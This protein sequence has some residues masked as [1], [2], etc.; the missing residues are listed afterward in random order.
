MDELAEVGVGNSLGVI[1]ATQLEWRRAAPNFEQ[2]PL[3]IAGKGTGFASSMKSHKV[4]QVVYERI[5]Q[6]S[7][8]NFDYCCMLIIASMI[9]AGICSS[10][11]LF[12]EIV[13]FCF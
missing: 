13:L 5:M 11:T 7:D 10:P 3:D 6:S 4:V 1:S 8:F 9:A 2:L 12:S